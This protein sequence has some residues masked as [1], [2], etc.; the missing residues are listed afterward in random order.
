M[1]YPIYLIENLLSSRLD[2]EFNMPRY[3]LEYIKKLTYDD[4]KN[5]TK[6]KLTQLSTQ[7]SS[8]AKSRIGRTKQ[9]VI[10]RK[11][12]I[13]HVL[14]EDSIYKYSAIRVGEDNKK[15]TN[16]GL[17][18]NILLSVQFLNTKTSTFKGWKNVLDNGIKIIEK[19]TGYKIP[20]KEYGL[21]YQVINRIEEVINDNVL[22]ERYGA[23][24][25]VAEAINNLPEEIEVRDGFINADELAT[26]L[27][28]KIQDDLINS[29]YS[30]E[31][32]GDN[33]L[34][35]RKYQLGSKKNF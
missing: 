8:Y 1:Q 25:Y 27:I 6:D 2:T 26:Y 21:F 24:K 31:V 23:Y 10:K 33:D 17:I 9:A 35:S 7:A 15:L 30:R 12:P 18:H 20:I 28:N 5:M 34:F 19:I 16:G 4:L 22:N 11:L 13:P 3:S 32:D 29:R 14:S